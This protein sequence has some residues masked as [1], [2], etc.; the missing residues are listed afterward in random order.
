M[1]EMRNTD[2]GMES[3]RA[4]RSCDTAYHLGFPS[5]AGLAQ[6]KAEWE[7][8]QEIQR[9]LNRLERQA[10]A[11]GTPTPPT[12]P[13]DLID[14]ADEPDDVVNAAIADLVELALNEGADIEIHYNGTVT[15]VAQ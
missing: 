1:N 6:T 12:P 8:N 4:D 9:T 14:D 5:P 3:E 11:S 15:R 10:A 2:Y 7:K 13:S